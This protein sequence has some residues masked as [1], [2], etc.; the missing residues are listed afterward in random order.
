MTQALHIFRKDVRH[1]APFIV[2]TIALQAAL[3]IAA[4]KTVGQVDDSHRVEAMLALCEVL[5]PFAWIFVI[6]MVVLQDPLVRENSF[7]LTRPYSWRSLLLAK[8]LFAL[9]FLNLPLLISDCLTLQILGLPLDFAHLL[10]RQLPMLAVVI[11]PAFAFA[12]NS[13]NISQFALF[14]VV[15]IVAF[16]VESLASLVSCDHILGC[17][18]QIFLQCWRFRS[19]PC[20][21]SLFGL[22]SA[23]RQS[24]FCCLQSWPFSCLSSCSRL[25]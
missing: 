24:A 6:A 18:S 15:L 20:R 13:R 7:W 10:L 25:S 12:A 11:I 19:L 9:V 16:L 1:L 2:V 17:V 22:R 21:F 8:I 14:L 5:L 4:V 23:N 3:A